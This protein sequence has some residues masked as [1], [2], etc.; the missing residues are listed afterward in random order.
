MNIGVIGLGYW[1]PNIV[2][3]FLMNPEVKKVICCDKEQKN[4]DKIKKQFQTVEITTNVDDV[5]LNPDVDA[6][7]VVT[8]VFTHFE[9]AKKA[10]LN[11]KHVLVEKPFTASVKEAEELIKISDEKGLVCMVDHTFLYT[12]AV[13]KIKEIIDSGELGDIY[14]FDSVRINLGLF[15]TDVNVVWDLAPHDFS[16]MYHLLN[17]KPVSL[18]AMGSDHVGKGFEDVA[19]VHL[20]FGDSTIAHF[21]VNWLSP[22]KIRQ[23]L[24]A[25]SKKMIV[26]D[27]MNQAD[28]VKVYNKGIDL[29]TK[30]DEYQILVNYRAGDVY[31]PMLNNIEALKE[32]VADF[33]SAI[34]NNTTPLSN[35]HLGLEVVK[36]LEAAQASIKSNGQ[37]IS[38]S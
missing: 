7:A 38:L 26:Y 30:E 8:P 11:G 27:D 36:V 31:S 37:Q 25:G 32:L 1:G 18:K 6:V 5:F 4:L 24:I 13:Q 12:P 2:R 28:K 10:L 3:N 21:H 17:K 20:D 14:Y 15:Q 9:L 33:L 22:V 23:C 34:N 29:K 35:K 19:Y 16:I